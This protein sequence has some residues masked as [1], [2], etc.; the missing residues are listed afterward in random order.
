MDQYEFKT[1]TVADGGMSLQKFADQFSGSMGANSWSQPQ[2]PGG[3]E[4]G[5][6]TITRS[7]VLEITD[8]NTLETI[9]QSGRNSSNFVVPDEEVKSHGEL[10]GT[11]APSSIQA[12]W[13]GANS[14]VM[15][16]MPPKKRPQ[17]PPPISL[18][19]PGLPVPPGMPFEDGMPMPAV[20]T[21]PEGAPG[22]YVQFPLGAELVATTKQL[23]PGVQV[24]VTP[25]G[26]Q[27]PPG[28]QLIE[29]PAGVI[30]T[31][32]SFLPPGSQIVPVTAQL[33]PGSQL[34]Q[35]P[36][37]V[38]L[39]PGMQLIQPITPLAA[40][41]TTSGGDLVPPWSQPQASAPFVPAIAAQREAQPVTPQPGE[42][43]MFQVPA[44][45]PQAPT[46]PAVA[47][48]PI[49]DTPGKI[50]EGL[51]LPPPVLIQDQN[52]LQVI[53][54]D[55][56]IQVGGSNF[57]VSAKV[58]TELAGTR[59]VPLSQ[60]LAPGTKP[61]P[62]PPGVL[63]PPGMQFVRPPSRIN[64]RESMFDTSAN[65]GLRPASNQFMQPPGAKRQIPPEMRHPPPP[66]PKPKSTG[67]SS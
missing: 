24:I 37:G 11:S 26:V 43:P 59:I 62:T 12:G 23:P 61:V 9:V 49:V 65:N 25:P 8:L 17:S 44:E 20:I 16:N 63:I 28:M 54:T 35:S 2:I 18:T 55:S 13:N 67:P 32:N 33:P 56:P 60:K 52:G 21:S 29:P 14:A 38:Q 31:A 4:A 51:Q 15:N 5:N 36:S 47:R 3:L 45:K 22:A 64:N 6:Y 39:P 19:L 10:S 53:Q 34:L 7:Y 42:L 46:A 1:F 30:N 27:L 66:K 50:P 40:P 58:Y 48:S 41:G 57:V